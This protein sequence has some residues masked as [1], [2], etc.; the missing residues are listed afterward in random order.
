MT[1]LGP[2]EKMAT[3]Q[4][5]AYSTVMLL[6]YDSFI[7]LLTGDVDGDGQEYM[8]ACLRDNQD[9]AQ[10]ITL[11][12]VAHHGSRYTTDNEFLKLCK[13]KYAVISCGLKNR[14]GH[15]HAELLKRLS[16]ANIRTYITRDSGAV[17]VIS[18]GEKMNIQ[19]FT[20]KY[21]YVEESVYR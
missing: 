19:E 5:N 12:K 21:R 17:S 18:D 6:Q 20:E 9:A 7:V 13:P 16:D 2:V 15:P 1:C 10:D 11:L 3:T 14:Y 4:P 8:K